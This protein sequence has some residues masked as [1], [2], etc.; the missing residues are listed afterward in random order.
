ML[1]LIHTK[2]WT[3]NT[4]RAR[5]W[6]QIASYCS[7]GFATG[8]GCLR[9]RISHIHLAAI[10]HPFHHKHGTSRA[11]LSQLLSNWKRSSIRRQWQQTSTWRNQQE[12]SASDLN[13]WDLERSIFAEL[14]ASPAGD[15]WWIRW[16]Y[17]PCAHQKSSKSS[18]AVMFTRPI[19]SWQ[20]HFYLPLSS[21]LSFGDHA[22]LVACP[23][24]LR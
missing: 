24:R 17:Y 1:A 19:I 8:F 2:L 15:L 21:Y 16:S 18:S 20:P 7:N 14:W 9:S 3:N 5:I 13:S 12:P 6:T 10:T 22:L 23:T 11:I 4:E